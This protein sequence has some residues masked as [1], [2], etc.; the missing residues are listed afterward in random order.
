MSKTNK[1]KHSDSYTDHLDED[2]RVPKYIKNRDVDGLN[3][4]VH[5]G[6]SDMSAEEHMKQHDGD[7]GAEM[8][9]DKGSEMEDDED[10]N[11]CY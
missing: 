5:G 11:S 4:A 3:E 9:G 2:G 7:H 10:C 1:S 6:V 8:V